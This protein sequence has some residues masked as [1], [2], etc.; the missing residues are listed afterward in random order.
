MTEYEMRSLALQQ[1]GLWISIVLVVATLIL[2]AVAVWGERIRQRWVRPKLRLLLDEPHLTFISGTNRRG[3]YY[4][5]H[6]VNDRKTSPASNTQ[7]RLTKVFKKALDDSWQEHQFSGP[8]QVQWRWPDQIPQ[9]ATIGP[10]QHATFACLLE[11]ADAAELCLFLTPNNLESRIPALE[12]TRL[13]FKAVSDTAESKEL[14][15]EVAS[16]GQWEE[17]RSAMDTHMSVKEATSRG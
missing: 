6:V 3:W 8:V 4:Q 14:V 5:L 2:A 7:V 16:D 13:H 12:P 10:D 17:G 1:W 9:Y 11:G 15:L